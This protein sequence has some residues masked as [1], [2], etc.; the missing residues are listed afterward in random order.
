MWRCSRPHQLCW[1]DQ[2]MGTDTPVAHAKNKYKMHGYMLYG[3]SSLKIAPAVH[4]DMQMHFHLLYG[5]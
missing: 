4:D 2:E 1:G 3:R 5:M